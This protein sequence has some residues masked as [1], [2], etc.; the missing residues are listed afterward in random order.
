[1]I[2]SISCVFDFCIRTALNLCFM[3]VDRT[4]K[5]N[6][7]FSMIIVVRCSSKHSTSGWTLAMEFTVA[8]LIT[9]L[10]CGTI[11]TTFRIETFR[12]KKSEIST[13]FKERGYHKN[14]INFEGT[15]LE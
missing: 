11:L 15:L 9:G 13:I 8:T 14:G 1:M 7:E 2:G 4:Q 12:V 10:D 3:T 5:S 6:R